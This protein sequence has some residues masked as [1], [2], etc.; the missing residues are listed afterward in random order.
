MAAY[1]LDGVGPIDNRP[2]NEWLQHFV[3]KKWLVTRD[4]W[5]G[6]TF[7]QNVTFLALMVWERQGF[8]DNVP[9]DDSLRDSLI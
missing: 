1:K 3:K 9:K 8:E 5:L 7:F 4:T 6:W 2:S